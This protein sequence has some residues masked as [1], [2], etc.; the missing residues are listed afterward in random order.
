MSVFL[1]LKQI[2][3]VLYPYHWLDYMMVIMVGIALIY[4]ILLVRPDIKKSIAASDILIVALG[5]LL[6]VSFMKDMGAYGVYVKVLSAFLMYFVGRIYYDRIKECTGA[7]VTSAYLVVYVNLFY[8]L[9]HVG[10]TGLFGV[11][12]AG[13]DLYYYDTDMAF[14]MI[15]AMCFIGMYGRNMLRKYM[16]IFFVCPYMVFYSDA[17]IQKILM[18]V[19]VFVMLLYLVEKAAGKKRM[20][21]SL[22]GVT[23]LGLLCLIVILMLP[24]FTGG[25]SVN[26]VLFVNEGFLSTG[27]MY[28]RYEKW[29]EIWSEFRSSGLLSQ[30]FGI[31]LSNSVGSMYLKT[32]Y[33]LGFAGILLAG[34]FIGSVI[35]YVMK[36]QDRKT[37]YMTVLLA[38]MLFGTGA[39]VDSMEATQM[40]WFPMMFAGMV[41]SSVQN[42]REAW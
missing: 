22:L 40:S 10:V 4:Q 9:Y 18:L 39:T 23:V 2:V 30:L 33:A 6:T 8:R 11:S 19:V 13:G 17:G 16:T 25:D 31:E 28:V 3:D 42:G 32:L 15:L 34:G 21:N 35:Y 12:N 5:I 41:I 7:L 14:A 37:F 27:N 24:V 29:R 20:M 26:S 1:F 36:I 38:V